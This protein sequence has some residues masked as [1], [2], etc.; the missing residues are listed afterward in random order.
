M[1]MMMMKMIIGLGV[2]MMM[3]YMGRV[4]QTSTDWMNY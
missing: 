2:V 1:M 3:L 4:L